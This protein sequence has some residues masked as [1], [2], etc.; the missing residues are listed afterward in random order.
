MR[1]EP[2]IVAGLQLFIGV[3]AADQPVDAVIEQRTVEPEL[4]RECL[5]LARTGIRPRS[6]IQDIDLGIVRVRTLEVG[7][8]AIAGDRRHRNVAE[9]PIDFA[10]DTVILGFTLIA[11]S[12]GHVDVAVERRLVKRPRVLAE[13]Q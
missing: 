9:V 2:Q 8:V 3:E 6:A 1:A 5:E 7:I 10:G 12:R 4:L 13:C 11:A